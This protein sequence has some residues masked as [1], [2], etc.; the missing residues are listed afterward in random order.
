MCRKTVAPEGVDMYPSSPTTL[1]SQEEERI[2]L[3]T[4]SDFF[5]EMEFFER[6]RMGTLTQD[7]GIRSDNA[8]LDLILLTNPPTLHAVPSCQ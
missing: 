5:L 2:H 3:A 1:S 8:Y 4:P 6:Q 7:L